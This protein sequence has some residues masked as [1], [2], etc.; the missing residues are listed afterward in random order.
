MIDIGV[1][2]DADG[3]GGGSDSGGGGGGGGGNTISR[4]FNN[5]EVVKEERNRKKN[6]M[7]K[8]MARLLAREAYLRGSADNISVIVIWL[9]EY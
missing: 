5:F 4:I 9:K 6:A 3:R 7:L 2:I 1:G 8:A